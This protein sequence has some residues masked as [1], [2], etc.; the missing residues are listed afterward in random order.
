VG[1]PPLPLKFESYRL[2]EAAEIEEKRRKERL[3]WKIEEEG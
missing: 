1:K 3:R 2:A